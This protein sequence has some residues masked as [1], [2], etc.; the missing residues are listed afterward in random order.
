VSACWSPRWLRV[1][2]QAAGQDGPDAQPAAAQD[3]P[4]A[5]P[6]AAPEDA[7]APD[8]AA[9]QDGAA[10]PGPAAHAQVL[11]MLEQQILGQVIQ[12]VSG[13]GGVASFLRRNLLGRP[14]GGP[15][16]PLDARA[17]RPDPGPPAPPGRAARP[18]L[19]L[20]RRV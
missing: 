18:R 8:G 9:A 13:P 20:P 5:Q 16:L 2:T 11:A 15:S 19:R 10:A 17:G 1:R 14:L 3:G 4:D 7:A 6:A 12:V